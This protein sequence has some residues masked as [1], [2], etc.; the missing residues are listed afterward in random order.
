MMMMMMMMMILFL[1]PWF[2]PNKQGEEAKFIW[3]ETPPVT[4]GRWSM[5]QWQSWLL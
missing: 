1:A 4:I 5:A 2:C 3:M